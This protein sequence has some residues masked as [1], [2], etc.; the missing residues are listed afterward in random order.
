MRVLVLTSISPVISGDVYRQVLNHFKKKSEQRGILCFPFFA[1]VR[2]QMKNQHYIPTFFSMLKVSLDEDMQRKLYDRKNM[3]VIGNTY[4]KQ[5]FDIV[6]AFK[7][8]EESKYFD[9][10][11]E[12]I[13]TDPELKEFADKVDVENLYNID[14]AEITLPTIHHLLLFLEGVFKNENENKPKQ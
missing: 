9:T 12:H 4:K 6:V 1:E 10:Y 14:D 7:E 5:N 3:I 11:I 2:S 13:K 8:D